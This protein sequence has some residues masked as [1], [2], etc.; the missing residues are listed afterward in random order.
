M[1]TVKMLVLTAAVA[2]VAV[3]SCSQRKTVEGVSSA[4]VDSVSY[5]L[6]VTL[7]KQL[8]ADGLDVLDVKVLMQGVQDA[9]NNK[10]TRY[11][12]DPM[13]F[14][15]LVTEF[16]QKSQEAGQ[17]KNI[18]EGKKFLEKNKKKTDVVELPSG[19]Q[20]KVITEGTGAMPAAEDTVKVHYKGTLIDG[21]EFDSSY[22]RNEPVEFPLGNVIKGWTEGLQQVKEG[23][24]VMLYIP[25]DLAYGN[26]QMSG[27]IIEPGSTLIFEV[28]LLEVKKAVPTEEE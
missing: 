10:R 1:K 16:I 27:S 20:Y 8:K 15:I 23:S 13:Q 19:L 28:E 14:N 24:K 22:K 6:G 12:I 3:A 4:Q 5:L 25:S 26:R 11:E 2:L 7:G 21:R 17:L 9:F 18:Q